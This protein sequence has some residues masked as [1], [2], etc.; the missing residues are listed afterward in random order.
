MNERFTEKAEQALNRSIA[1][2]EELGHT[3]IGTEHIMLA[4]FE[5]N[6]SSS[7]HVLKKSKATYDGYRKAVTDYSGIG[8][9][10]S[11]SGD[12]I[13]PRCR[14]ILEGAYTVA[15]KYLSSAVGT[16]HILYSLL[17]ERDCIG[18]KLLKNIGCDV[19]SLK[20][21][22]L[23]MIRTR[24]HEVN[25]SRPVQAPILNQYGKNFNDL[26]R[27]DKFDPVIGRDAET[28]RLI[29]VLC[30]KNKNNPCLIG[31]AG[32]GKSAIV[33]GLAG[34][35]IRGEVPSYLK[36]KVI[37]SVDLTSMVAGAKYRGDFE[38]RVKGIINEA[39]R[40]KSIILFIDEIHT[41]VGAGA[42]EGAIDASNILKPQLSRGE[43]QVIGATT[44]L[45]YRKYIQRDPALERRFQPITIEE[46]NDEKTY[47]MLKGVKARYEMHHG[48]S[49]SDA[50]LR[51]CVALSSKYITDRFLPDKALDLLDEA[52]AYVAFKED[53]EQDKNNLSKEIVEQN[54]DLKMNAVCDRDFELAI[55]IAEAERSLKK[56]LEIFGKQE[57]TA[58]ER[59]VTTE[60]VRYIV[61]EMTGID[62][63]SVRSNLDYNNLEENIKGKI[64]GQDDAVNKLVKAV[65]RAE[66][67]LG[68]VNR[69]RGTFLF[70]GGSGVGKTALA[71]ALAEELFSSKSALLRFDM[72][73][74]SEKYSVSK[75]I[76]SPPGYAGHDEGG[77]LTES[78]RKRPYSVVLFDEI[79]KADREVQNLFLQIADSGY[80]TDSSGK[81]I[82]FRN[83]Y[84]IMTSNAVTAAFSEGKQLGFIE[85][86]SAR[87]E[88]LLE[89]LKKRFADEFINRFDEIIV[90]NELD[91]VSKEKIVKIALDN[92]SG[93]LSAKNIHLE[94]D[95]GLVNYII[96]SVN[97]KTLGARPLLHFISANIENALSDYLVLHRSLE[98]TTIKIEVLKGEIKIAEAE[99][100][101]M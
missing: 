81:R 30:R 26:A 28:D 8:M 74:Y 101:F 69:P 21:D 39:S 70:V 87:S 59:F 71:E 92:L 91:D 3:Y 93:K 79:E 10:S 82:S 77:I 83:T 24:S 65:K 96:N 33:E 17:D 54:S 11:L 46:P 58:K 47:E 67:G 12:D 89:A 25:D 27:R 16:E 98:N 76:G 68:D 97:T 50:V 51:E 55:K 84:V 85:D 20:D 72:S 62:I 22:A 41:I 34:R 90:F 94:F 31:E 99:C 53:A 14:R 95:K 35:I 43:L 56:S 48:V 75:L 2:A 32:V 64:V 42:A 63:M 44:F 19:V 23:G 29:R 38:E 7:A 15:N 52:C 36:N 60:D 78:V 80:L 5:D 86:K 45:E 73:E 18:T 4:L 88:K 13:T 49:I 100:E 61:S 57:H 9:K 40:N 6:T 66:V 1:I 37:I